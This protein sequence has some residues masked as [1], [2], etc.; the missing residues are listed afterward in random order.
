M[1]NCNFGG[2]KNPLVFHFIELFCFA[3]FCSSCNNALG[4]CLRKYLII[5]FLKAVETTNLPQQMKVP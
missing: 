2:K 1:L 3:A 5:V 4:R